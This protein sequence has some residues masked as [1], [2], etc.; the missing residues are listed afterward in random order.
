MLLISYS[1]NQLHDD[2]GSDTDNTDNTDKDTDRERER[3]RERE[4]DTDTDTDTHTQRS[5]IIH[6]NNSMT[7]IYSMTHTQEMQRS[8]Y[9][10]T[11]L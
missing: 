3:E 7:V 6:T 1:S 9:I 11:T 5:I 10:Q 2:L 4:R 8:T